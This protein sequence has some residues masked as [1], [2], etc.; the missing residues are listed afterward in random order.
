MAGIESDEEKAHLIVNWLAV[1]FEW[2]ATDYKKR[3]VQQIIDRGGGNCNDLAKVAI[4][5]MDTANIK[6]R[7]VKEINIHTKSN[8]RQ[9]G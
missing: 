4:S 5:L 3:S 8:E 9:K 6:I 1:N 2:K 7:K